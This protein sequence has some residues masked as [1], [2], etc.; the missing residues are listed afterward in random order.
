MAPPEMVKT[1]A[2]I[3]QDVLSTFDE[4]MLPSELLPTYFTNIEQ[5]APNVPEHRPQRDMWTVSGDLHAT[6]LQWAS[7]DKDAYDFIS[8]LQT[9]DACANYFQMKLKRRFEDQFELYD[10]VMEKQYA[11]STKF[12]EAITPIVDNF[13]KLSRV[14]SYDRQWRRNDE[15]PEHRDIE[16]V[17]LV[18]E[19]LQA[20]CDRQARTKTAVRTRR[21][22]DAA[23]SLYGLLILQERPDH[24][25]FLLGSLEYCKLSAEDGTGIARVELIEGLLRGN[26]APSI[27]VEACRK[28][29]RGSQTLPKAP[30]DASTRE[31]RSA[32]GEPR[33]GSKRAPEAEPGSSKRGR[34]TGG[35]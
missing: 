1:R 35:Q 12:K 11:S 27:Y 8:N 16:I 25:L 5:N 29:I 2:L 14:L 28:L 21:S 13:W 22:S 33:P 15:V 31:T 3:A 19:T 18:L 23:C 26:Q 4:T 7:Y 17:S 34:R 30:A 9:R 20:V 24:E 6:L 10:A 32:K